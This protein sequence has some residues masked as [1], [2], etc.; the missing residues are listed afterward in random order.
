MSE[1]SQNFRKNNKNMK[2][3][4][5]ALDRDSFYYDFFENNNEKNSNK[6][7]NNDEYKI[8]S[9]I[10]C[11]ALDLDINDMELFLSSGILPKFKNY[12][13]IEK[14]AF[15][16]MQES[17][18][19][20]FKA[21]EDK[22]HERHFKEEEEAFKRGVEYGRKQYKNELRNK[23]IENFTNEFGFLKDDNKNKKYINN[24]IESVDFDQEFKTFEQLLNNFLNTKEY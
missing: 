16:E 8:I 14:D 4:S 10:F 11:M 23:I 20:A 19:K 6:S 24:F 18:N 9:K 1:R 12:E 22:E 3:K 7:V 17:L 13:L 21:G 15:K 5:E 2:I